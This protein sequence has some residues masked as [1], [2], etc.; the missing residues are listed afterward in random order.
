MTVQASDD[1]A[2]VLAEHVQIG[3]MCNFVAQNRDDNKVLIGL[4]KQHRLRMDISFFDKE[5]EKNLN[6]WLQGKIDPTKY[7]FNSVLIDELQDEE[8]VLAYLCKVSKIHQA[9][10]LT[11]PLVTGSSL[12][13]FLILTK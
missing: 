7:G 4:S 9:P 1:G 8:L 11:A 10:Y 2:R 13:L 12:A 5:N 6:Y 3:D